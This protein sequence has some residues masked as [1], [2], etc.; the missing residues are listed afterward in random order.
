V[1]PVFLLA[2]VQTNV[3]LQNYTSAC[4]FYTGHTKKMEKQKMP[5]VLLPD[6]PQ[7]Y[8]GSSKGMEAKAALDCV[9]QVWSEADIEAFI[10][11]ICINNDATARVYLQHSIIIISH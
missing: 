4:A 8:T 10:S 7:N 3:A 6:C 5:D 11:M 9:N 1:I 2:A